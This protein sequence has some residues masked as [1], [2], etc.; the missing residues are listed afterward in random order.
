MTLS[1]CSS[2]LCGAPAPAALV[3][4]IVGLTIAGSGTAQAAQEGVRDCGDVTSVSWTQY[5]K[6]ADDND[7][8]KGNQW[9]VYGGVGLQPPC[10][11][12]RKW[13]K[14]GVREATLDAKTFKRRIK[15]H[16]P[17]WKCWVQNHPAVLQIS[18]GMLQCLRYRGKK[19]IGSFT[20]TP[21]LGTKKGP[22]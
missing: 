3:G 10:A 22:F 5:V 7:E 15:H 13:T 8:Y 2:R 18:H 16:P 14:V 20:S 17:G 1:R 4:L 19:L 9:V 21:D 12:A 11:F 6:T